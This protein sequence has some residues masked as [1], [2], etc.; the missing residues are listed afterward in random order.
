MAKNK[1][2]EFSSTPANNTDIGGINIAEGCAPSGINNAIREL[3]AQ[4]KDQQAG[5]DSDSFTVGGGFTCAG[6]A[7][8]SSTVAISGA[9]TISGAVVMSS[10]VAMNGNN[11]IGNTTSS[12]ILSGTVTQTTASKLYLDDSVTTSAAPPLSWDGDTDTGVYRPAANTMALVT[13]GVDRLRVNSTGVV[14]IGSGEATTSVAGNILRAPDGTGT[15]ITGANFEINAGNGT[16]TGGSGNIIF[17]TA[18]V[19]SSGSDANTMTQRL[20]ITKKGG[21][22][23]GS[24]STDYGTAGQVLRSNGDAPPSFSTFSDQTGNAPFYFARAWVNFD[25][26]SSGT[27]DGGSSTVSRTAGSTTATV[28]TTNDHGLI[29]GNAVYALTGVVAGSYNVT[30]TGLKTFTI[31]TVATTVLTAAAITFAVNNIRASG[32]VS[33]VADNGTGVYTVNFATAMQDANYCVVTSSS[34]GSSS[35][36]SRSLFVDATIGLSATAIR[37]LNRSAT[38][39]ENGS[40]LSVT[41]FR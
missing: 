14:I 39:S 41:V 3:M 12:T 21:F 16:G 13:A 15:N 23:F 10:T 40:V 26:A 25:G 9:T 8:F 35:S 4:L 22:S 38:A 30:V 20:L 11:N 5:T 27:F 36:T 34:G 17:K 18:D 33:S 31:T 29:T 37:L 19:G 2:S 28:T 32:N 1:I 24:G 6:A 7:V